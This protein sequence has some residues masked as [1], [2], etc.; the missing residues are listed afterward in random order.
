[1]VAVNEEGRLDDARW[2]AGAGN[3]SNV[4][5]AKKKAGIGDDK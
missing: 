4:G 2:A 3:N 5:K 1:M